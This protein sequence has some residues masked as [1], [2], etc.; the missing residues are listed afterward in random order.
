[1]ATQFPQLEPIHR[2]FML[3]QRMFFTASAASTGRV[4]LSP[5][6][7][8]SLRVLGPSEVV[9]LDL[10]G[11]GNET[12]AHLRADGRLTLMF[13]AFEGP[14]MILRLYGRGQ[15]LRQGSAEYSRLLASEFGGVE[16]LGARQMVKLDIDLVQKSCGYGVPL[17]AFSGDRPTLT[18]WAEN[19]G[20]EGLAE[21][22]RQKNARSIDGMPTGLFDDDSLPPG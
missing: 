1:M 21:Y 12:A 16:P 6:G 20:A 14:P 18:R 5:K 9:Y 17:Y 2:D 4:N 11:S 3:R 7:L 15:V 19:K 13:C 22:R 10:T 8:D